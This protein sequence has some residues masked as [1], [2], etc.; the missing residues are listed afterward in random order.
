MR[1]AHAFERTRVKLTHALV[2][3]PM[4]NLDHELLSIER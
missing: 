4:M 2:R 1:L 3:T